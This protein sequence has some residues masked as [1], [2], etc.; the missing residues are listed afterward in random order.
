MEIVLAIVVVYV[1]FKFNRP[2][3]T[4]TKVLDTSANIADDT[5]D[6]YANVVH[7]LN[8]SKRKEQE[9]TLTGMGDIVTAHDID[10]ILTGSKL[11][12][13]PVGPSASE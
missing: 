12:S 9:E 3:T 13:N 6:T 10:L 1:I 11:R 7:I 5:I 4:L 8:A 2:L